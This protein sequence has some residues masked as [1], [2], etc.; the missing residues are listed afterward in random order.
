MLAISA[1]LNSTALDRLRLD[2]IFSPRCAWASLQRRIR[3]VRGRTVDF[4]AAMALA[5]APLCSDRVDGA[6]LRQLHWAIERLRRLR[7]RPL[8]VELVGEVRDHK[9]LGARAP[10]VLPRLG[11]R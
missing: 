2:G 6:L 1:A 9:P 11:R 8:G 4:F 3:N 10:S 5:S 7:S